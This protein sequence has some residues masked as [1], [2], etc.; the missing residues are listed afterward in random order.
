MHL[1]IAEIK[2]GVVG[3]GSWGSA[4]AHLLGLKGFHLDWWIYEAEVCEQIEKLRENKVFLP[5][6][7]IS[8]NAVPTTD[9][10]QAVSDKDLVAVVVPSHHLRDVACRM[11]AYIGKNTILVSASKGIENKTYL[12]MSAVLKEVTAH[13]RIC[14]LSG[15]SF[16]SEVARQVPT[17]VTVAAE[18]PETAFFAQHVFA[19]PFFR[20]YTSNDI[21]G[22]ELGGAVK[23]VIAIASGIVDGLGL[24]FNT[25]AALIT[26]GL[27]EIRRLGLKLGARPETFTGLAGVGDLILTCT[28]ELSRNHTVGKKIGE[29][30][31]LKEILSGMRM[32]AE[33]IKTAES[34]YHL[35]KRL[36]VEMPICHQV[37]RILYDDLSPK[38]ALYL[39]MTRELKQETDDP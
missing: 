22:V 3:G 6:I 31:K 37:Y 20:V 11:K 10:G 17:V 27:V 4:I 16:A 14:V 8:R 25:R 9:I 12:T 2:V 23:N 33:G 13:H 28:G 38:E 18:E 39:L 15:P 1:P 19:A 26:R 21:T 35:S 36:N 32:V 34:V 30:L 5:E 24:G 7:L 29:G